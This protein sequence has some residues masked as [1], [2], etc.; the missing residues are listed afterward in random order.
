MRQILLAAAPPFGLPRSPRAGE[1]QTQDQP[2]GPSKPYWEALLGSL[3][4]KP[5]AKPYWNVTKTDGAAAANGRPFFD[6]VVA[7]SA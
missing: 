3:I 5:F 4:G 6:A 7:C 1:M 2:R